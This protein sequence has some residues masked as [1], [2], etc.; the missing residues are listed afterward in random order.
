MNSKHSFLEGLTCSGCGKKYSP[1]QVHTFCT[2]CQSTLLV[3][4]DL[5]AARHHTDRDEVCRRHKG[6]WRWHE[7]LPILDERNQV[8]L[9]EGDTALLP[10]ESLG[11]S[12]GLNQLFVKEES[13]NPTGSFKARGLSAAVSKAKELGIKK[14]I[15]PTAGNAGGAMA[16]YAAR[17]GMKSMIYMPKDTPRANIEESRIVGAEVVLIDGLISDAAGMAGIKAR[18]EGWFDVSTFKEPYRA[19]G[20][21]IMGY[22]LAEQF[23]W[24]LPD[25]IIYPTG[26]GTGLVGMWK[27]FDE[28]ETLGWLNNTKRPRM[29]SVQAAGCAPVPR[30][31][32]KK[33]MFCD[34]WTNASTIASGL[35]VPKS[36]ADHLILKCL[37]DSNGTAVAVEDDALMQAQKEIAVAEGIFAAPEGAATYA[38]LKDLVAQ[39]WIDPDE[40]VVLFNT[41]SGLKY[42][43]R[44]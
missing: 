17:A 5:Q 18:E 33:A 39:K 9:G 32:E 44:A 38:A 27:A 20:K 15:I 13:S 6:M 11:K 37:Y 7:V 12:L 16:S 26:G 29:V 2:D 22:E 41:G 21:K 31:F 43:D 34:F 4:Y 3:E 10:L 1:L 14:V 40:R 8:T 35:R 42:L 19:E 23:G 28:M 30:A 36:F 24:E 25:V